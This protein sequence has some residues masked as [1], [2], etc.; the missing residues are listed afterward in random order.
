MKEREFTVL[1]PFGGSGGGALGFLG[2]EV[3]LFGTTGRFRCL[4][5]IDFD[6]AACNDFERF[7]GSHAWCVD[8]ETITP[9]QVREHFG[10]R[11]PD[12]VFMSPP[13]KGSSRLLSKKKARSS[14]YRRMNR[15]AVVWTIAM[16]DAWR[17]DLPPLVLLENVPGLPTRA[18]PMLRTLR[19]LLREAG[20]VFHAST[21]D[22]GEIGGL[23]QHRD[24]YLLVARHPKKASTLL[25]Q[26]PKRR[27]RAC[28]E[29]LEQLPMPATPDARVWGA[30]HEMPRIEWRNWL[31]LALIPAGG[32]W[33][34]LP[35]VLKAEQERREVFRRH[36][37]GPW[38]APMEAVTGPGGHTVGA[39]ADP[40]E[41]A[42][43]N[44]DRVYGID[45]PVH[46]IT[47]SPSPSSGRPAVADHRWH[48]GAWGVF[49]WTRHA[50]TIT[51]AADHPARGR[52]TIADPRIS[53][54]CREHNG[55]H[56]IM[57]WH[58]P[59]PA[60][61]GASKIDNRAVSVADPRAGIAMRDRNWNGGTLGVLPFEQ[62]AGTIAG[63]TN[64]SNGRFS[65]ADPRAL[66]GLAVPVAYDAGYGVLRM[67]AP[68][69]TVPGT[70]AVGTGAHAVADG[71]DRSRL[72][73]VVMTLDE[74]L[75]LDLPPTKPPPFI[76][77]I[78]ARDNTWHRPLTLLEL[79]AL[80]GYPLEIRG[81]RL[82][83]E[84][85]RVQ[86]AEHIGNSV[87]PPAARAIAERMLVCLLEAAEGAWSLAGS[88][89][90]VWVERVEHGLRHRFAAVADPRAFAGRA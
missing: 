16:L 81:E 57:A 12:V 74:A 9:E 79:A 71:R 65:V 70:V 24:R 60:V 72:D 75:D 42:F 14:K 48:H 50:P 51:G 11:R 18:R 6:R 66:E 73:A 47:S 1:C 54:R 78:V 53:I 31:R 82:R 62:P 46:V 77:V 45:E 5:S 35:G 88:N 86:V 30:L 58:R 8:V 52:F 90:P 26:P 80:Q 3:R 87:P 19:G 27:V 33:R 69:R 67:D 68:A 28:G 76:P 89:T 34:D 7:T 17:G 56:G 64:P 49:G 23:A 29:V 41:R 36:A 40:R 83:F 55:A 25:Y 2:A 37:V 38:N 22:C 13:C 61:I 39:I 4:G 20:Y 59:S 15:L 85:K 32:D 21:H 84:G 63:E 10:E 44:V 43:Y